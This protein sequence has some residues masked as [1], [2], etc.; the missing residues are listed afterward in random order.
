MA[1]EQMI[2]INYDTPLYRYY[3]IED[4]N[5]DQSVFIIKLNHSMG[6][7]MAYAAYFMALSDRYD[8]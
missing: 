6:D 1:E 3:I 2:K 4:Y 7:G 5:E 8:A